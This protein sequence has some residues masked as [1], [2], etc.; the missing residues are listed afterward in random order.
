[1]KVAALR[2]TWPGVVVLLLLGFTASVV[3]AA[4]RNPT[5]PV[6][7]R[8]STASSDAPTGDDGAAIVLRGSTPP[9]SA[10]TTSYGCP[11]GYTNV[12]DVGCV[13]P[14]EAGYADQS[15]YGWDWLP[16]DFSSRHRIFRPH[17]PAFRSI[18]HGFAHS[19]K[20]GRR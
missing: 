11:P 9:P 6:T 4:V 5:A 17:R 20:M 10:P 7:I 12:S 1:M 19:G 14:D 13:L 15:D 2:S 16:Y 8:G 18:A 3:D